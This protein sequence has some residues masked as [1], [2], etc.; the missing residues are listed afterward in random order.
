[1]IAEDV[2][3]LIAKKKKS[4]NR[5]RPQTIKRNINFSTRSRLEENKLDLPGMLFEK[6]P[7]R[8]YPNEAHLTHVL[9]YLRTITE[10]GHKGNDDYKPGDLY[11]FSGVEKV[12]E[13]ILRGKDGIEY[14]LVDIYGID[15]GIVS[16]SP[17]I[18]SIPG[19]SIHLSIDSKLQFYIE[20]LFLQDFPCTLTKSNKVSR[21]D[22]IAELNISKAKYP[23]K[24]YIQGVRWSLSAVDHQ[25]R[26]QFPS[27]WL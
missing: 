16:D 7:A 13:S 10:E 22:W 15:H 18:A 20:K 26:C 3:S 12:Y 24:A 4:F 17:P 14:H 23:R 21:Q 19:E 1:M 27:V 9:G 11:G 2:M 5:F 25:S 6:F 8:I